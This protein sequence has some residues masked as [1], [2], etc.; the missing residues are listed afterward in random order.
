M[1]QDA[2]CSTIHTSTHINLTV[3]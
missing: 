3:F 2:E 1:T